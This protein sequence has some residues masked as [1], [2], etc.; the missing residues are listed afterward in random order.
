MAQLR[1]VFGFLVLIGSTSVFAQSRFQI[2]E[3]TIDDIHDAIQR[4]ETTC[5]QVVQAYVGC[6]RHSLLIGRA[7]VLEIVG[8]TAGFQA[9]YT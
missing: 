4:G 1:R 9:R 3:A 5:A 6:L 8:E 7:Q 2:E